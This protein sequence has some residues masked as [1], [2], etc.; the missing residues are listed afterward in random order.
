MAIGAASGSAARLF[1]KRIPNYDLTGPT[2][3]FTTVED[4]IRWDANFDRGDAVG[5]E[6]R[7]AAAA[8]ADNKVQR[9]WTG[10]VRTHGK[11]NDKP[12]RIPPQRPNHRV[13]RAY[14]PRLQ[15]RD[16]GSPALQCRVHEHRG[17]GQHRDRGVPMSF[18]RSRPVRRSSTKPRRAPVR[19]QVGASADEYVGTYYS[20]EIDTA[21]EVR[22]AMGLPSCSSGRGI[23][24][25][26]TTEDPRLP[27]DTFVARGFTDVLRASRS[28]V[29]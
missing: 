16:F 14:V 23:Q 13:P 1:E 26:C 11:T 28:Y 3:L 10:A 18:R 4:L 20:S 27:D 22:C 9:L 7:L 12:L 17:N 6:N 21:Y 29:L 2:N 15:Q 8:A 25:D 24:T 19:L 5:G